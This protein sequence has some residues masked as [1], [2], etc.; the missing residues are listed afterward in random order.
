MNKELA[1]KDL[2]EIKSV[3]DSFGLDFFLIYG[4]ALGAY[5]DG[6]FLDGDY[7]VDLGTFD[8][9]KFPEIKKELET[10][11]FKIAI[12]YDGVGKKEIPTKMILAERSVRVDTYFFEKASDEY[13]AWK[14]PFS[15]HPFLSMPLEFN[16]TK[17]VSF[18]GTEFNILE[19]TDDY[20]TYLY[21][22][23]RD[24]TNKR[25]GKLYAEIH[26]IK[27]DKYI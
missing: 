9:S 1:R 4:T 7:D 25:Q 22:D 26:G 24:K 13:V 12:C 6:D 27:E 8:D 5:R 2:L 10:R 15:Y 19:P 3:F 23:W 20:L 16:Q 17:P 18:L 21:G 14:H 11:G